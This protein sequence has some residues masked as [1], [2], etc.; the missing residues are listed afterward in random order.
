MI[1][2]TGGVFVFGIITFWGMG[3][4][5]K[6]PWK[7]R[8]V[9]GIVQLI[10]K[11]GMKLPEWITN[12]IILKT[13]FGMIIASFIAS[14]FIIIAF[15]S[16]EE[17]YK[18]AK[19]EYG[20]GV[21]QEELE[22]E[23]IDENGESDNEKIQFQVEERK[24]TEEE[25]SIY[26]TQVKEKIPE[27][28]LGDNENLESIDQSLNLVN[29][30]EGIPV[31]ISWLSSNTEVI[32]YDGS[33]GMDIPQEGIKVCL[34][35][36]IQIQNVEDVYMQYITVYPQKLDMIHQI[37]YWLENQS[38]NTEKWIMLPKHWETMQLSWK[39][40]S[41]NRELSIVVLLLMGPVFYVMKCRQDYKE[42]KKN[43]QEQLALD[44]PRI[45]NKLTLL[46][47][48][49]LN[50]RNAIKRIGNDYKK[51]NGKVVQRAAYE[52]I[53]ILM[54]EMERGISEKQAYERF[55][56][57]CEI[58]PYRTL[59]ALLIQHLQKGGDN[60]QHILEEECKKA[61]ESRIAQVKIMGE[62]VSTKLLFPMIL[63]LIIVFVL[64]L[65]PA[66]C[67]FSI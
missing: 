37:Q 62:K 27:I 18:I 41:K 44:Y 46:L 31:D 36:I 25:I 38:L 64:I 60:I 56:E 6:G 3:I 13:W 10:K 43:R 4:G 53:L 32:N 40:I 35:A 23:W 49:G 61:Q 50:T 58:L 21:I 45:L 52:E 67:S 17:V 24:L 19:P 48:A 34:T 26:M 47:S 33:L 66:W 5:V 65:V 28:I 20:Q 9:R 42:N 1:F 54:K 39:R 22:I 51:N 11:K 2:I 30:I 8:S 14:L 55:G 16:K 15:V 12:E 57:R 7:Y 29:S 59:A 63:M